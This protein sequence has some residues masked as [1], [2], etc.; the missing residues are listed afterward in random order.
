MNGSYLQKNLEFF[1]SKNPSMAFRLSLK[2]SAPLIENTQKSFDDRCAQ[3]M[4]FTD[5]FRCM[6]PVKAALERGSITIVVETDL[7][8]AKSLMQ[9]HDLK[10]LLCSENFFWHSFEEFQ[11]DFCLKLAWTYLFCS[12]AFFFS[13]NNAALQSA[14]EKAFEVAQLIACDYKDYGVKIIRNIFSNR[15]KLAKSQLGPALNL[16]SVAMICGAGPSVESVLLKVEDL[17]KKAWIF[18]GG[19][20]LEVFAKHQLKLDVA[21]AVDPELFIDIA[22]TKAPKFFYSLRCNPTTA[23]SASGACYVFP[24]S[25]ESLL[26]QKLWEAIFPMAPSLQESGWNVGNFMTTCALACGCT[27]IVLA[28][29]DMVYEQEK[30]YVSSL[31]P[32]QSPKTRKEILD[33]DGK[34]KIT[35][36]DFLAA[37]D[38]YEHLIKLYPDVKFYQIGSSGLVIEGIQKVELSELE[39]LLSTITKQISEINANTPSFEKATSFFFKLKASF[40]R[41]CA[42]C[43]LLLTKASD[44]A[45]KGKCLFALNSLEEHDLE[46]ELFYQTIVVR[47]WEIWQWKI[48]Q[49]LAPH[50]PQAFL[51]KL[52]FIQDVVK[53]YKKLFEDIEC[54][55]V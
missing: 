37:R 9:Q 35:R 28:G 50:H 42:L 15:Y 51:K 21:A 52:L 6:Q 4:F 47:C 54:L 13:K 17:H 32:R 11:E 8:Q 55:Q 19:S 38:F 43:D 49:G 48:L 24:G 44:A 7:G 39:A 23:M 1:Q 26:E 30:E 31:L 16:S 33:K 18:A 53:T 3:V 36:D 41:T 10:K 20:A 12:K 14:L 5:L 22:Q 45:Q 34:K 46:Q 2:T 29:M 27:H 40:A 25:G